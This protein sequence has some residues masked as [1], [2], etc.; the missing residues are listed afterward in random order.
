MPGFYYYL[1]AITKERLCQGELLDREVLRAR[2]LDEVLSDVTHAV[3][4][5]S[6]CNISGDN[7]PDKKSGVLLAIAGKYAGAPEVVTYRPELHP[8]HFK[9]IGDGSQAWVGVLKNGL[10]QPSDLERL[11]IVGGEDVLDGHGRVWKIPIARTPHPAGPF[12]HLPQSFGFDDSGSPV[13]ALQPQWTWLWDLAGEIRDAFAGIRN[14]NV[15]WMVSAAAKVL[16]VNYRLGTAELSLL[17]ELG[18][19]VLTQDTVMAIGW[20][21][22]GLEIF[23]QAKKNLTETPAPPAGSSSSSTSGEKTHS[24]SPGTVP[25]GEP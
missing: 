23:E 6:L 21:T 1:P 15:P 22:F 16:G 18:L 10:P 9:A 17:H 3:K 19:G 5:V 20:V 14:Q 24:E 13:P 2:G 8:W 12:G 11:K 7:G 25:V 4:H